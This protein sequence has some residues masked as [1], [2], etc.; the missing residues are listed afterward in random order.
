MYNLIFN[1]Q[2]NLVMNSAFYS[3]VHPNYLSSKAITP[4]YYWLLL[5]AML[6]DEK[7]PSI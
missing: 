6:N 3:P 1:A 2:P 7:I 5:N 4:R